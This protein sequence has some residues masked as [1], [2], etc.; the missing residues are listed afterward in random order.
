MIDRLLRRALWWY[1]SAN[2]FVTGEFSAP[3]WLENAGNAAAVRHNTRILRRAID[4]PDKS[5]LD[6]RLPYRAAYAKIAY[7]RNELIAREI[8]KMGKTA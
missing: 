1:R 8:R 6:P 3:R 4:Y 7:A 2:S 5:K